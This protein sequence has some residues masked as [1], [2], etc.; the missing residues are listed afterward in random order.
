MA[1][2]AVVAA[3]DM[4]RVFAD[5]SRAVVTRAA[6]TNN[7]RM[8][9]NGCGR[10]GRGAMAVLA[11]RRRLD[12]QSMLAGR[13]HAIMA[14]YAAVEDAGMI[15]AGRHPGVGR[16]AVVALVARRN[17]I[18]CLSRRLYAVMT[19]HAATP[20]RRMVHVGNR[21][22]VGRDVAVVAFA[23]RRDVVGGL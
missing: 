18:G 19:G 4:R 8:V 6:G 21:G 22:P 23:D 14:G 7:L 17:M 5:R 3:L 1:V 11:D 10:E 15:E 12:V 2:V 20:Q 16:V 9:D 13:C